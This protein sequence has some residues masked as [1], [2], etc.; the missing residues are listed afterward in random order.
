[1]SSSPQDLS[2]WLC[3]LTE[4]ENSKQTQIYALH[5][6]YSSPILVST[7]NFFNLVPGPDVVGANNKTIKVTS[8]NE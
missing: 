8:S 5:L 7:K 4:D 3:P 2:N 6:Q 1:M